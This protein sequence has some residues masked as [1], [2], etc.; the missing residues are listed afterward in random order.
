[1]L[2]AGD[3]IFVRGHII[4]PVADAIKAGEW[5]LTHEDKRKVAHLYTHVAVYL[6]GN[7]IAEAQG[8][9]VSGDGTLS[10]YYGNYDIGHVQMTYDQRQQFLAA[11]QRENG[12]RYD[13]MGIFWLAVKAITGYAKKY[14]EH[15]TRY[16][17]TY[18]GWALKQ[19][20][21]SVN[22]ETPVSLALD[23]LIWIE[24]A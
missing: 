22:D 15:R 4:D 9:R 12:F 20:G 11:L 8:L 10:R 19:A 2:N 6:G 13:W 23:P 7:E 5:L 1:M 17:S 16:C 21:V 3:L 14:N 18:V 24:T